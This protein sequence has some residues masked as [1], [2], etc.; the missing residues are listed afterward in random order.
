MEQGPVAFLSLV[1]GR[2]VT[3]GPM[4]VQ[5]FLFYLLVSVVVAYRATRWPT[6][7]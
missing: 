1:R 5:S 6:G 4:L 7:G 3:R 2:P